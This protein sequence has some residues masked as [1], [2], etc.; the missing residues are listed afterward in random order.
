MSGEAS[1]F[2][3]LSLNELRDL[4]DLTATVAAAADVGVF[5][6][7]AA[8]EAR[9]SEL[10]ERLGLNERSLG[11]VLPVLAELGI[12]EAVGVAYR[13][14]DSWRPRLA[15]PSSAEFVA[16]GLP[17]WLGNLGA[18]TELPEVLRAGEQVRKSRRVR[19]EAAM[20][21]FL[22][23][24]AAAP[25]DRID[26]IVSGCMARCPKAKTVLDLGAGPGVMARVFVERGL[27]VTMLDTPETIA[28]TCVA[29][30]LDAMPDLELV[31]ADFNDAPLPS[32]PF[33][34]VLM[35]NVL[36]IYGPVTCR[37]LL[38]RVGQ[39]VRPG[40]V[41]AIAEFVRGRSPRAARLA[42]T[43][44]LRTERGNT[45]SEDEYRV[46]MAEAGFDD[47]EIDDVDSDRQLVTGIRTDG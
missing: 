32:G 8:G 33:D 35:S 22:A 25:R 11:I 20:R 4:A 45:Y 12:L 6:A 1:L 41:A 14:S 38:T 30:G 40:G 46:W 19:D 17:L 37:E 42:L 31:G 15:D 29:Y 16:G 39:V 44:L 36:H 2:S 3:Q 18:L 23:G 26:R 27:R 21:R 34:I 47:V 24:M 9:P 5:T 10:A 13:M 28:V 43:M 7:L